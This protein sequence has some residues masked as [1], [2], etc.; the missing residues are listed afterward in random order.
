MIPRKG[1]SERRASAFIVPA[2]LAFHH[3]HA[4]ALHNTADRYNQIILWG[5]IQGQFP[6]VQAVNCLGRR[7]TA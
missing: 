1:L 7:I 2:N 5:W 4:M 6:S 3:Y